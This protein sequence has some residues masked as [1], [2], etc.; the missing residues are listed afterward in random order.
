MNG[1]YVAVKVDRE[2][3]PDVDAVYMAAVQKLTG[4]GG[5]PMSMWLTPEREP[6]YRRHLFPAA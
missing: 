3:R 6:F 1:H 5:W 4:S 2:E